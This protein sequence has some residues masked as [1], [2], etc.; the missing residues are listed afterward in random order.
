MPILHITTCKINTNRD[1]RLLLAGN[2]NMKKS[3]VVLIHIGFW[4]CYFILVFIALGLYYRSNHSVFHVMNALKSILLFAF[5]PSCISYFL[6]YFL[7]FP[8]YVQQ[9][10]I[11]LSII[12]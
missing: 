11:P 5:I 9:K 6:Y 8:K 1:L 4:T 2:F 3:F 12:Y 7:L 10:K